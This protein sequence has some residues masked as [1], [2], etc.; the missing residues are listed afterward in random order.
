[1]KAVVFGSPLHISGEMQYF[2]C[3]N[4]KRDYSE[5]ELQQIL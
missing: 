4:C 3:D 2:I 1:M 5:E